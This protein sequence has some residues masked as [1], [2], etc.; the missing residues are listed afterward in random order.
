MNP[1]LNNLHPLDT[2]LDQLISALRET[3]LPR[4]LEQR[5]L[6]ALEARITAAHA[7]TRRLPSLRWSFAAATAALVIALILVHT[8]QIAPT[9]TTA[10]QTNV[11]P[12]LHNEA[13]TTS[14]H[15]ISPKLFTTTSQAP[16]HPSPL[17]ELAS[18]QPP[19]DSTTALDRLALEETRA[20]SQSTAPQPLTA[21]ERL[22][23]RATRQGQP[24][25]VA[26]LEQL[27]EPALQAREHADLQRYV[28]GLFAPLVSAQA[29]QPT[30]TEPTAEAQPD[31][32]P[33]PADQPSR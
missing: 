27:R 25:E 30:P 4:G 32:P 12:A 26:E 15:I 28:H 16:T 17:L 19:I 31:P 23:L 20:P 29:L 9:T 8:N 5:T 7:P 1:S 33:P 2:Q 14:P 3:P 10:K 11:Q 18:V 6:A 22:L 21:Q 13:T 24:I